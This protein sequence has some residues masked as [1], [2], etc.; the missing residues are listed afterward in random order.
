MTRSTGVV[1]TVLNR[2]SIFTPN[3]A[4]QRTI[5]ASGLLN[6]YASDK[7]E[8]DEFTIVIRAR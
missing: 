7:T 4:H 8:G 1:V 2:F 6:P 5:R 3:Q